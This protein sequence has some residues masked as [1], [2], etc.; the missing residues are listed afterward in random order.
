MTPEVWANATV[1]V[2]A[3]TRVTGPN[4]INPVTIVSLKFIQKEIYGKEKEAE[5]QA[6]SGGTI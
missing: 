2:A 5:T 1:L 3:V 4:R 6:D